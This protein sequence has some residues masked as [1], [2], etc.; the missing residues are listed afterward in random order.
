MYELALLLA[1]NA[2]I[3]LITDKLNSLG[4]INTIILQSNCIIILLYLKNVL[5]YLILLG[6]ID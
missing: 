5:I 2:P 1:E 4:F 3:N 6:I